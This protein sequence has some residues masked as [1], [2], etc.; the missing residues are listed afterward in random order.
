MNKGKWMS[1][2]FCSLAIAGMVFVGHMS[3]VEASDFESDGKIGI[4]NHIGEEGEEGYKYYGHIYDIE[5]DDSRD[6]VVQVEIQIGLDEDSYRFA[7]NDKEIIKHLKTMKDKDILSDCLYKFHLENE[8]KNLNDMQENEGLNELIGMEALDEI[9]SGKKDHEIRASLMHKIGDKWI[10]AQWKSGDRAEIAYIELE[11]NEACKKQLEDRDLNKIFEDWR[12]CSVNLQLDENGDINYLSSDGERESIYTIENRYFLNGTEVLGETK[13]LD[14]EK[15]RFVVNSIDGKTAN[16]TT[17]ELKTGLAEKKEVDSN[18]QK[19]KYKISEEMIVNIGNSND[20]IKKGSEYVGNLMRKDDELFLLG[21]REYSERENLTHEDLMAIKDV[22]YFDYCM[23]VE[24]IDEETGLAKVVITDDGYGDKWIGNVKLINDIYTID[25]NDIKTQMIADSAKYMKKRKVD[26]EPGQVIYLEIDKADLN[27]ALNLEDGL[28]I[29]D[30]MTYSISNFQN[31]LRLK[32]DEKGAEKYVLNIGEL[33]SFDLDDDI[34]VLIK[35]GEEYISHTLDAFVNT[36]DIYKAFDCKL[37]L[38][39]RDTSKLLALMIENAHSDK[40]G[41]DRAFGHFQNLIKADEHKNK[42]ELEVDG[43]T[44]RLEFDDRDMRNKEG[45][46]RT[47]DVLA[48]Y[49]GD[50]LLAYDLYEVDADYEE[51]LKIKSFDKVDQKAIYVSDENSNIFKVNTT[52]KEMFEKLKEQSNDSDIRIKAILAD[53]DIGDDVILK[54]Y[55]IVKDSESYENQLGLGI[56]ENIIA[57]EYDGMINFRFENLSSNSDIRYNQKYQGIEFYDLRVKD[58][59]ESVVD[60]SEKNI[61]EL[62]LEYDLEQIDA[63]TLDDREDKEGY[64]AAIVEDDDNKEIS[65]IIAIRSGERGIKG[66]IVDDNFVTDAGQV[67]KIEDEILVRGELFSVDLDEFNDIFKEDIEAVLIKQTQNEDYLLNVVMAS[68]K[69]SEEREAIM[70]VIDGPDDG[71]VTIARKNEKQSEGI[72]ADGLNLESAGVDS[73]DIVVAKYR[74]TNDGQS[75][76]SSIKPYYKPFAKENSTIYRVKEINGLKLKL[77][78]GDY[79]LDDEKHIAVQNSVLKEF[80]VL[81]SAPVFDEVSSEELHVGD[82]VN[83]KIDENG[84]VEMIYILKEHGV[85]NILSK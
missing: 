57:D 63:A 84:K 35:H 75:I 32:K 38:D 76:I 49:S 25:Y 55:E 10:F 29:D 65:S 60:I 39:H 46:S 4:E 18:E 85:V 2:T 7:V 27:A 8:I 41:A 22:S 40:I 50:K 45:F 24:S 70:L 62:K 77:E 51:V 66:K 44:M 14:V 12:Y 72:F 52:N 33:G 80:K 1:R 19:T 37:V 31:S 28:M 74:K 48:Y 53:S 54:S 73:K 5:I 15:K 61:D 9:L 78:M 36:Y 3:F 11:M 21:A 71:E 67:Y 26:L 43:K 68:K 81:D 59:D 64:F 30:L 42:I 6:M 34:D 17:K 47:E 69:L 58:R 83:L 23:I 79:R 56:V 82:Y 16:I 13:V 20:E